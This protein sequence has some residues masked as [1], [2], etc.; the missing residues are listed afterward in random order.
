MPQRQR[1]LWFMGATKEQ[2]EKN[3]P[4]TFTTKADAIAACNLILNSVTT[5]YPPD[6]LTP[7]W[8]E[9]IK[10]LEKFTIHK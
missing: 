6:L 3:L 8:Q 7:Y 4:P 2:I 9:V 1:A 10:E 5:Y